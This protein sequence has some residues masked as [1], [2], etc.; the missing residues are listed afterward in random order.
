MVTDF[1]QEW[2]SDARVMSQS[3]QRR[4]AILLATAV[5]LPFA[6]VSL[7]WI[8]ASLFHHSGASPHSAP[9]AFIFAIAAGAWPLFRLPL[10]SRYRLL[11]LLIYVPLAYVALFFYSLLFLGLVLRVGLE[12][13]S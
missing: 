4:I 9:P 2:F 10:P 8:A 3:T 12:H 7:F 5:A 11:C 1:S 13:G 6:L